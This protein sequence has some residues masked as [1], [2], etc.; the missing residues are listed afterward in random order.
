[1]AKRW[2]IVHAYSGFEKKVASRS[3]AGGHEGLAILIRR[4]S[5]ADRR[6]RRNAP[7]RK[8][9]A[10]ASSS[11]ATS[12]SRWNDRRDLAPGQE[13]AERSP[14]FWAASSPRRSARLKRAHLASGARRRRAAEAVD[15]VRSWRTGSRCRRSVH[16]VQRLVE[17]V[18][19]ERH[20]S[21]GAVSIFGRATPVNWNTRRSKSFKNSC[22]GGQPGRPAPNSPK[23]AQG[24]R[25]DMAKKIRGYIKLQ[26]PAGRQIRRRRLVRR[27]VSAA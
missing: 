6:S 19:E 16:V 18:D 26:V 23:P 9:S 27:S 25:R 5:G 11:R 15:H 1:M 10:S 7:R 4:S 22:V 13:Y 20:A 12:W 3:G 21:Q 8:V 2:Y 17:E 24:R 14:G